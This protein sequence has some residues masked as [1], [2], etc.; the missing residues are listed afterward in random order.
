MAPY[1]FA[2]SVVTHTVVLTALAVAASGLSELAWWFVLVSLLLRWLT[3][4]IIARSLALPTGGLWLLPLRD[5]LS[6]VVFLGS[7]CGRS[8][9]WRDQLFRVEPG[10]RMTVEGDKPV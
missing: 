8:V 2:G 1:G 4:G 9:L 3:A 5:V 10:G 6:F 7:F